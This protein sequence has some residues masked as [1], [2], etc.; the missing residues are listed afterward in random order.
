VATKLE[1]A[2]ASERGIERSAY[3]AERW[4]PLA[5]IGFATC[6]SALLWAVIIYAAL[7]LV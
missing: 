3:E 1:I 5:S 2:W 4:P 7:R 6:S